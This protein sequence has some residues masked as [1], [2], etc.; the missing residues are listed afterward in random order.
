LQ[1]PQLVTEKIE[2]SQPLAALVSQLSQ[3]VAQL[4]RQPLGLQA[5]VPCGLTQA[6]PQLWQLLSEPSGVSQP[7]ALVQSAKPGLQVESKQVPVAQL[8]VAFG[9][10]HV[11]P[12]SPQLASV[13]TL[14]SQPLAALPSQLFQPGSQVGVQPLAV[15]AVGP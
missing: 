9:R 10:S 13:R 11:M 12:Q 8:S 2:V 1:A 6:S 14:V 15:Q 4:G 5:V 7:A 3:P